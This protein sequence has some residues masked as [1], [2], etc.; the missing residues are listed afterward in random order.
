MAEET[1]AGNGR[2]GN[3]AIAEEIWNRRYAP[4]IGKPVEQLVAEGVISPSHI[5]AAQE[6]RK[7]WMKSSIESNVESEGKKSFR[8]GLIQFDEDSGKYKIR[9]F[10]PEIQQS[11]WV[12][13]SYT[14]TLDPITGNP[15]AADFDPEYHKA[16]LENW[17]PSKKHFVRLPDV[18]QFDQRIAPRIVAMKSRIID[19]IERTQASVDRNNAVQQLRQKFP[20]L[21]KLMRDVESQAF[22]GSIGNI[23]SLTNYVL[24]PS[25]VDPKLSTHKI[26]SFAQ[27]AM[28]HKFLSEILP[29]YRTN[30][31]WK[32]TDKVFK[33]VLN[34]GVS[35]ENF[36]E[37]HL[38]AVSRS[39]RTAAPFL[40]E[41]L[42][43]APMLGDI[44]RY[45]KGGF[46]MN[47]GRTYYMSELTDDGSG[48]YT[49]TE[50]L[51]TIARYHPMNASRHPEITDDMRYK[52]YPGWFA[53]DPAVTRKKQED[54]WRK[55][56]GA[57][58]AKPMETPVPVINLK[59]GDVFTR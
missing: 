36:T 7:N 58:K 5:A 56:T 51:E 37:G 9:I 2:Y 31:T 21:N 48:N 20:F 55:S 8:S 35:L 49:P 53:E 57:P 22:K 41:G 19:D 13:F 12:D 4:H 52:F 39:A 24:R 50:N 45:L 14:K 47:T 43:S 25:K 28:L 6:R 32:L 17:F 18:D 40:L 15:L 54:E 30:S 44:H 11:K 23:S 46:D 38:E 33:P 29:E 27:E 3:A 1:Q 59:S 26:D 42:G 10:D 34:A 16:L